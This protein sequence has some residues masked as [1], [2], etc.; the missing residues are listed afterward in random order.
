MKLTRWL[1]VAVPAGLCLSVS[2]QFAQLDREERSPPQTLHPKL[3]HYLEENFPS[4]EVVTLEDYPP[5]LRDL[6]PKWQ[7]A[8]DFDGNGRQD[9]CLLMRSPAQGF[10]LVVT[11][12]KA[13][14]GFKHFVLHRW[15]YTGSIWTTLDTEGPGLVS[16][17]MADEEDRRKRISAAAISVSVLETCYNKLHYWENGHFESVY[18]GL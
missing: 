16:V 18:R 2:C 14:Y 12:H 13:A 3:K 7:V 11:A 5:Y 1:Y 8:G 6:N 4:C 10:L 9:V 17:S 15:H